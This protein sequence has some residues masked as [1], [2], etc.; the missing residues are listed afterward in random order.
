[1]LVAEHTRGTMVEEAVFRGQ[2]STSVLEYGRAASPI[3]AG[4]SNQQP[5]YNLVG[6]DLQLMLME[7]TTKKGRHVDAPRWRSCPH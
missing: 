3:K 4:I 1:V 5:A 2:P 6:H 7:P